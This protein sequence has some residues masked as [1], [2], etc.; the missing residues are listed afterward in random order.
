VAVL[1][2]GRRIE[3]KELLGFAEEVRNR[4]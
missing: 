2:D 1:D 4:W 3:V